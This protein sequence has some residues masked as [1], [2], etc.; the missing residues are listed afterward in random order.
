MKY[1]YMLD[2]GDDYISY[3]TTIYTDT[4]FSCTYDGCIV[5]TVY[6]DN[7]VWC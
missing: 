1:T 7:I 3:I 6:F 4:E 2:L 5:T